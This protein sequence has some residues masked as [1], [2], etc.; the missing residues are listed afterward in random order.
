MKYNGF[1]H[2]RAGFLLLLFFWE[3]DYSLQV[4]FHKLIFF[5]VVKYQQDLG[6]RDKQEERNWECDNVLGNLA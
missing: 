2:T 4:I 1:L 6:C 3:G 5:G